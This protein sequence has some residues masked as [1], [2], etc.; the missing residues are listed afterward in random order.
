V[1]K[2]DV[3]KLKVDVIEI[4]SDLTDLTIFTKNSFDDAFKL[5]YKMEDRMDVMEGKMGSMENKMDDMESDI[6][7]IKEDIGE[8]EKHI[9]RY[10]IRSQNIEQILLQDHKPRI[11]ELERKVFA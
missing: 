11:I 4:K 7:D 2:N 5:L 10:E 6:S 8:I 1:L 9:G 3:S